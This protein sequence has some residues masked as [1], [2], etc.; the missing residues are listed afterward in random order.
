M[1]LPLPQTCIWFHITQQE[2]KNRF[3]G[4]VC[5][6]KKMIKMISTICTR[7]V[8]SRIYQIFWKPKS[9]SSLPYV[10]GPSTIFP[11][12][13]SVIFVLEQLPVSHI[14]F[15]MSQSQWKTKAGATGWM[16][17]KDELTR[18]EPVIKLH[19]NHLCSSPFPAIILNCGLISR[20]ILNTFLP[21]Y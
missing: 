11:S 8:G 13:T 7:N 20:W 21:L 5:P 16:Q 17:Q 4:T 6:S 2:E 19:L 15:V 3:Q 10:T 1:L 12:E 18:Q 14:L 9:I